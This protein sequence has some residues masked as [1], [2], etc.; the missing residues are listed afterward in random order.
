[1]SKE[2]LEKMREEE[3]KESLFACI[4]RWLESLQDL[5]E[6]PGKYERA[7]KEMMEKKRNGI[8][9]DGNKNYE[10]EIQKLKEVCA[11][12][13]HAFQY[14]ACM[15]QEQQWYNTLIKKDKH[16]KRST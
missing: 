2:E 11:V 12:V 7:I 8:K 15:A 9:R 13:T 3:K 10:I 6:F 5:A 1:M 4:Q 16:D 14:H